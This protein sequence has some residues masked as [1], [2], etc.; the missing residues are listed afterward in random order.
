MQL[1][2]VMLDEDVEEVMNRDNH[3]HQEQGKKMLKTT[4]TQRLQDTGMNAHLPA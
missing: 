3:I 4:H 1:S 2:T